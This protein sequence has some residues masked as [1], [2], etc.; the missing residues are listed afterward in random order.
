MRYLTDLDTIYLYDDGKY[1]RV[2]F[3]TPNGLVL[4]TYDPWAV[5]NGEDEIKRYVD[6]GK[7]VQYTRQVPRH[8]PQPK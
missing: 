5:V 4:F 6:T 1:L 3:D 7:G 2:W 8:D